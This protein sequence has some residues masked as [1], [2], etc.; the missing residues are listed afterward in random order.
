MN[1]IIFLSFFVGVF[2]S[3]CQNEPAE[4]Q[5]TNQINMNSDGAF[6]KLD[7]DWQGHR[8]ARG[9]QPENSY[10]GF[11][12]AMDLGVNTLEMD[13]VVTGDKKVLVSHEP[14][15][16]AEFC[17]LPGGKPIEDE[18]ALNIYKMTF[19]Q[20]QV[21]DCGLKPH[22]R[23]PEQ[24]KIASPKPLLSKVIT[25]VDQYASQAKMP[26]VSYSIEIK[27]YKDWDNIYT[28]EPKE[29]VDLV[30]KDVIGKLD[31]RLTLQSFD[32]RVLEELNRRK[33]DFKTAY[34]VEN[35][36]GLEMN[37]GKLSFIPDIYSPDYKLLNK[38]VVEKIHS[39]GMKVVP[40]T[41]NEISDMKNLIEMGV[42]GIIT[43]YPNKIKIFKK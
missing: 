14:W 26:K 31:G 11:F 41:V 27:S 23:F 37:L 10:Y 25:L 34:L 24:E 18:K 8:G 40:W 4:N 2:L 36:E 16:S 35:E 29:F 20:L 15:I 42:D 22:P 5:S 1:K 3:S 32:H 33:G 13:V 19:A 30:L 17:Q 9:L 6:P 38:E 43:D 28:P 12:A 21:Y 7:F 39:K